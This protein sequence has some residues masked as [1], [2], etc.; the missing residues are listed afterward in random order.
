MLGAASPQVNGTVAKE[1][2]R[3]EEKDGRKKEEKTSASAA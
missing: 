1:E 3:R 2:V